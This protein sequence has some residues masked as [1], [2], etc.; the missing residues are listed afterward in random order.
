MDF[1]VAPL[2]Q[3]FTIMGTN[4]QENFRP[5]ESLEQRLQKMHEDFLL[6][7]QQQQ[8]YIFRPASEII[9]DDADLQDLL[10]VSKR[11]T[12]GLRDQRLITYSQPVENG[13]VFYTLAWAHD[14]I[15]QGR[16]DSIKSIRK[17]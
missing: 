15:N 4:P 17:Y 2:T 11:Y 16:V 12:A 3:N 5:N 10:H 8:N 14:F 1:G 7:F 13:K 6:R 9:I